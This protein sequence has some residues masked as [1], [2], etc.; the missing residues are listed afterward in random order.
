MSVSKSK[1]S[2]LI[3]LAIDNMLAKQFTSKCKA[4][5]TLAGQDGYGEL[6]WIGTKAQWDLADRLENDEQEN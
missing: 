4:G 2:L 1:G 3:H 6:E 5:L